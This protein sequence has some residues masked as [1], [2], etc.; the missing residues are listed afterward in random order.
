M[1]GAAVDRHVLAAELEREGNYGISIFPAMGWIC[2]GGG[3]ASGGAD[4]ELDLD[5]IAEGIRAAVC[6]FIACVVDVRD[7]QS[8]DGELG[9]FGEQ[10]FYD[11]GVLCALHAFVF[12]RDARGV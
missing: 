4:G 5:A 2:A 7:D 1:G 6:G 8:P 11:A 9:V 3:C 12:D 10:P